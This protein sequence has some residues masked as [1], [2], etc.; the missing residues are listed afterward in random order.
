MFIKTGIFED[1]DPCG[2]LTG[3]RVALDSS[4]PALKICR[5]CKHETGVLT[6]P[7]GPHRDGVRCEKCYRHLGWLPPSYH[8]ETSDDFDVVER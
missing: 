1:G 5:F 8:G 2:L 4:F 3:Q 6:G 7:S